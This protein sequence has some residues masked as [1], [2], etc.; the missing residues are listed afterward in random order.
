MFIISAFFFSSCSDGVRLADP[1]EPE[2]ICQKFFKDTTFYDT[3]GGK[4]YLVYRICAMDDYRNEIFLFE[5]IGYMKPKREYLFKRDTVNKCVFI[6]LYENDDWVSSDQFWFF[7]DYKSRDTGKPDQILVLGEYFSI[8]SC[9]AEWTIKFRSNSNPIQS[10]HFDVEGVSQNL[11]E[12]IDG[13]GFKTITIK[14]KDGIFK[15]GQLVR[16]W[17]PGIGHAEKL[18]LP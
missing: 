6:D 5:D 1:I 4:S 10:W 7:L 11:P 2:L 12:P 3:I 8:N 15:S 18:V 17:F 13:D 16:C 9:D 14:K